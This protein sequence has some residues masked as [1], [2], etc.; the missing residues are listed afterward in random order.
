MIR[1]PSYQSRIHLFHFL[2]DQAKSWRA[3][4]IDFFLIAEGDRLEAQD[5]FTFA[6]HRVDVLFE[7]RRRYGGRNA[8]LA[9]CVYHDWIAIHH[10][11]GNTRHV[12]VGVGAGRADSD[13][14]GLTVRAA[15]A[16]VDV[17][18]SGGEINPGEMPDGDVTA[19]GAVE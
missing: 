19:A 3:F 14:V 17:V 12:S 15:V 7:T 1:T 9:A 8:E 5:R 18:T 4:T 10:V 16:N 13:G 2:R 6:I 11:V